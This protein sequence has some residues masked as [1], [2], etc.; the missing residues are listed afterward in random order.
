[1]ATFK[2]KDVEFG[3]KTIAQTQFSA[4]EKL[5]M[6]SQRRTR[7]RLYSNSKNQQRESLNTFSNSKST[8]TLTNVISSMDVNSRNT[9]NLLLET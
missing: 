6:F 9:G 3:E 1:M 8:S 5:P 7:N 2:L 4:S